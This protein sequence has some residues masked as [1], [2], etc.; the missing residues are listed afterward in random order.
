MYYT[1]DSR[2]RYSE[3]DSHGLLTMESLMNY[4]QDCSTFQSEDNGAGL[5]VM[6]ARRQAWVVSAWQVIVSRYPALCEKVVIGTIPYEMCGFIGYRN[7]FLQTQEGEPLAIANSI[8]SLINID[9][10][11][12]ERISEEILDAYPIF[13]K[14]S[15]DYQ[16]RKIPFPKEGINVERQKIKVIEDYLDTNRHVNNE[17][18]IRMAMNCLPD[19]NANIYQLRAEYK[20]Q[21]RLGDIICPVLNTKQTQEGRT[22]YTVALNTTEKAAYCTVELTLA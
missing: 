10:G 13:E 20:Q 4:F 11:L 22:V 5:A 18:Y 2:I 15:M 21:A 17:Q 8:W 6:Y 12:P 19:R 3:V 9:S 14:L 16:P 1:F 7:F